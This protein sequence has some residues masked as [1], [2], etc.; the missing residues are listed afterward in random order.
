LHDKARCTVT[1]LMDTLRPVIAE[2]EALTGIASRRIQVDKGYPSHNHAQKFRVWISVRVRRS[3]PRSAVRCVAAPVHIEAEY[4]MR[5]S[6]FK[7][8]A[9]PVTA[10]TPCSPLPATTSVC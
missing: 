9:A 3:P 5:R 7:S 8:R 2:L 6:Y 4:R 10:S 1:A